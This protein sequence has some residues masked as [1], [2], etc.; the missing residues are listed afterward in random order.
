VEL[1][2][3]TGG[4]FTDLVIRLDDG[5]VKLYKS[6]TTPDDPIRGLFA[7]I[8]LAAADF[9]L[10]RS[11]LLSQIERLIHATTRAT[12]AIL[13]E[14]CA[15]TALL[16]TKGHPDI[17]LF[18]EGG[19]YEI[20]NNT[21]EYPKPYVPRA[22]TYE[23]PERIGADGEIVRPLDEDAMREILADVAGNNVEAV[24]VCLI[25]STVN[26]VHERRVGEFLD[27]ELPGVPY[28]LSHRLNPIIREYRRASATAIDASLK[29][30]MTDYLSG[31]AERLR[32][33]GFA[34]RV[35]AVTAAGGVRD[36]DD[37]AAEPI[38]SV[39][40]GPAMAPVAGRHLAA[41]EDVGETAVVADAGGTSYDV[42]VVR[43]GQIPWTRE[44]WLG[45]RF[46][47]HITGFASVDVRSIGAGGGSLAWVDDGGLLHVGP[48]SA[49]AVP[50]PA[51]YLRGGDRPTVTD[52]CVVLGYV[53][54]GFFLGGAMRL[55]AEAA[56][57]AVRR[58]VADE[59]G[60]EAEEAAL[61]IL[62][63]AT[64]HMIRAIEQITL[65]QGIDPRTA[66]LVAGG[67]AAGLNAGAIARE[68]KVPLVIIP[69]VAAAVSAAGGLLSDLTA[70]FATTVFVRSDSFD[71]ER[72]NQALA[73]LQKQCDEFAR[74]AGRG[75][76]ATT[77]E[78]F[79]E[80]R[81]PAQVWELEVRLRRNALAGE[82]DLEELQDDF[83]AAH[84]E[85]FAISDPESVI[86]FVSWRARVSCRI[87][88]EDHGLRTP[89]DAAGVQAGT[90][91]AYFAG[92]GSIQADVLTFATMEPDRRF[93]GPLIIESPTTTVVVD[94]DAVVHR[95]TTGSLLIQPG[96][97]PDAQVVA[98]E[99]A[100]ELVDRRPTMD[101]G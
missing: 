20:F 33:A 75:A 99:Q 71:F 22:L 58:Y 12:N 11:G 57:N 85:V 37:V 47:G 25:W 15:R 43:R 30:L 73:G 9:G 36:I 83:H 41:V 28:T 94:A 64:E 1:V 65:N 72:V 31:L 93:T 7:V 74:T 8:D 13:T 56:R 54:P 79:T 39:G 52:A 42:S 59:L 87:R 14:H 89:G 61:A 101:G 53:D 86:E 35:L 2:V 4:T 66:V 40:S 63:L 44:A 32:E 46:S 18:R 23:V 19:R 69:E 78:F 27:E 6:P 49:G 55:D 77:V 90:R 17:L 68:L 24:A 38:H 95:S 16:V 3:D 76:L 45:E 84:A 96:A 29:P 92:A 88:Q 98:Q 70:D 51:C 34:G 10:S 26:P 67:G 80:A 100:P 82:E 62:R 81:Y 60:V 5:S 91:A 21:R 48:E 97:A 50:G